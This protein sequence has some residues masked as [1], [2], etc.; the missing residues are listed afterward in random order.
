MLHAN[1]GMLILATP[2]QQ[3]QHNHSESVWRHSCSPDPLKY[4]FGQLFIIRFANRKII[5]FIIIF[6]NKFPCVS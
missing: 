6:R 2:Q 4:R 1:C 5:M 3:G